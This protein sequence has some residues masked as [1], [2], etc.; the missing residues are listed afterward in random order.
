MET[1]VIPIKHIIKNRRLSYLKHILSRNDHELISKV[2]KAQKRKPAKHDWF[3]TI[4]NDK[5]KI[6]LNLNDQQIKSMSKIKYK[7]ILKS[8]IRANAFNELNKVKESHSKVKN[9]KY[10]SLKIQNYL[11]DEHFTQKEKHLL[12]KLR[13]KMIN[14]KSNFKNMYPDNLQC[15]Y[16]SENVIQSQE[17]LLE[18]PT[19][20]SNCQDLFDNIEIE[21]DDIYGNI[22]QQLAVTKL[23]QK[24]LNTI[25]AINQEEETEAIIQ[26][27]E[28]E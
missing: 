4:T 18:C 5:T 23:Y 19:I 22:Q 9:I 10:K 8:K 20:I 25:D 2:Y 12:F 16:C 11:V 17:H 21:H 6:G 27:E 24:V 26:E 14:V 1:G 15:N 13:T 3:L 7:K 28:T